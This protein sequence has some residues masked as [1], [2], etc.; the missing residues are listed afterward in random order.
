VTGPCRNRDNPGIVRV[1]AQT[2]L[3]ATRND[4]W[5]LLAEPRHLA[6]WWPDYS[7]IRPDR[8][9]LAE[10]A[11]W[12]GVRGS[13]PGLLRR[14][15][16]EGTLVI[17]KAEPELR[18][19]WRDLQQGFEAEIR[20]EPAPEGHTRAMLVVEAPAWRIVAE[21]LRLTPRQALARLHALCQTA[22]SL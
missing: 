4:V 13:T 16:G 2:E 17:T 9:G 21:G 1:E 22:A 12:Q 18:L 11:R 10:G 7:T 14:P 19:A 6:D 20:L 3:I 5:D 8:R 15:S